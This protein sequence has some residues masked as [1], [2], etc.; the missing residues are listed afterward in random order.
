VGTEQNPK[1]SSKIL[2]SEDVLLLSNNASFLPIGHTDDLE[3]IIL[4]FG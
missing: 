2:F 4:A 1:D 3:K